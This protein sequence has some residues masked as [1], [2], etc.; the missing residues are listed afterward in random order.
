MFD[1]Y[2]GGCASFHIK[3]NLNIL[4]TPS[5]PRGSLVLK[6]KEKAENDGA[7]RHG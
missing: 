3:K 4:L 7:N 6:R 2:S 5:P 1:H